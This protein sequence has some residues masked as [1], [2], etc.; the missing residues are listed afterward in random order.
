MVAAVL[1]RVSGTPFAVVVTPQ[2]RKGFYGLARI[3]CRVGEIDRDVGVYRQAQPIGQIEGVIDG[4]CALLPD[5]LALQTMAPLGRNCLN[6]GYYYLYVVCST[7]YH[8]E[9]PALQGFTGFSRGNVLIMS[10]WLVCRVLTH[11]LCV[12]SFAL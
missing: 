7:L 8:V 3:A 4:L 5:A 12:K 10:V 1:V 9:A 6:W 11:A 2:A